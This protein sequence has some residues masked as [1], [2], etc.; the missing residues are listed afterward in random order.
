MGLGLDYD[1][2][3]WNPLEQQLDSIV[4]AVSVR[5][6]EIVQPVV[7]TKLP[8]VRDTFSAKL[9]HL[10]GTASAAERATSH[11]HSRKFDLGGS[12]FD[13]IGCAGDACRPGR[14][15]NSH[16]TANR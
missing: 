2:L 3:A 9:A 1:L 15:R 5:T 4:G 16:R 6:I 13:N 14:R 8:H 10:V 11:C 7:D 12:D